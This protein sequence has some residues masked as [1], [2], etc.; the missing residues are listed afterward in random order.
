MFVLHHYSFKSSN[1][2]SRTSFP[3]RKSSL[4]YPQA[5]HF[6]RPQSRQRSIHIDPLALRKSIIE[7]DFVSHHRTRQGSAQSDDITFAP[8][9][10]KSPTQ[11]EKAVTFWEP[12]RRSSLSSISEK[13]G[14]DRRQS[15]LKFS[16][17][18]ED[19]DAETGLRE[20]IRPDR[21]TPDPRIP[22][23]RRKSSC[24]LVNSRKSIYSLAEEKVV[25][26]EGKK[27]LKY[28]KQ[29]FILFFILANAA[30]ISIVWVFPKYWW[31]CKWF[32]SFMF[33][34]LH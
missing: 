29:I 6:S 27:K 3:S 34:S 5:V 31:V 11:P 32:K 2:F 28:T 15:S 18:F 9:D 33:A 22:T 10:E 30:C 26:A 21:Y 19:P 13:T 12:P 1:I 16:D 23:S 4:A 14:R 17:P 20:K 25:R 24:V 8:L 7:E